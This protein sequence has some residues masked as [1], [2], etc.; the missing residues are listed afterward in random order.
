MIVPKSTISNWSREIERWCPSLV[1]FK[2]HGDKA[3]R[4]QLKSEYLETG[5]GFDVCITTC[6]AEG[7]LGGA[8]IVSH[9]LREKVVEGRDLR[10]EEA[11]N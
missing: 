9:G 11:G 2:F 3:T 4:A 7:G 8:A 10:R 1:A 6:A 5:A